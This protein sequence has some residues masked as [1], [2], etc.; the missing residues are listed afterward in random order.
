MAQYNRCFAI[1]IFL[2]VI[3][4]ITLTLLNSMMSLT[5]FKS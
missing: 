5:I 1:V 3:S 4:L 2:L